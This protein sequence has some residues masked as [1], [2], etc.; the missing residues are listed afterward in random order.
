MTVRNGANTRID[1]IVWTLI[2]LTTVVM[3]LMTIIN[4]LLV[5]FEIIINCIQGSTDRRIS[6]HGPSDLVCGRWFV[7]PRLY[8]YQILVDIPMSCIPLCYTSSPQPHQK[9][10]PYLGFPQL[11]SIVSIVHHQKTEMDLK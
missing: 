4:Q 9:N 2:T 11:K 8:H 10:L 1:S 5:C 3:I 6:P 7:D